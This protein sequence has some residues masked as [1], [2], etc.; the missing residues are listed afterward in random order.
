[1]RLSKTNMFTKEDSA[2]MDKDVV[3]SLESQSRI[4]DPLSELLRDKASMLLKAAIEAECQELL[5]SYETVR[6]LRGHRG[7]VRNGYLPEREVLTG[8]GPVAVKVP[9]VRDRTGQGIRF[10][11]KLAPG[12]VRRAASVDAVLPWLY[13]KG[14][15]QAEVGPALE[16]LL[17]S[18]VANLSS[19]VVGKLKQRWLD[20]YRVWTK[21]DLSKEN[22]VYVW[23]DGVYSGVRAEDHRLCALVVVGVDERGQK[24]FL[25]IEDGIRESK[26]SWREVLIG[27]KDRG[28]RAP[29]AATGDGALGFWAAL[30]EIFP[31]TRHQ[32]CWVHKTINILNYLPKSVQGKAKSAIQAIWMA[33]TRA[34]AYA[35]FDT[36]LLTYCCVSVYSATAGS[37]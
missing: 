33:D 30:D 24:H 32:R 25:A 26:Q 3:V 13:L 14:I 31:E 17:G 7:V 22:W 2:T 15:A 23:A 10:E 12:Y 9:R 4:V 19:G 18:K 37:R 29:K 5:A 21:R 16:A 27:L 34:N 1:M 11:S 8:L 6:D 35:A 36:F 28:V 20:E